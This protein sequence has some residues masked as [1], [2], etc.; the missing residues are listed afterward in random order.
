MRSKM[1]VRAAS[2]AVGAGLVLGTLVM[3]P[4]ATAATSGKQ[5]P[6]ET[7]ELCDLFQYRAWSTGKYKYVGD[8]YAYRPQNAFQGWFFNTTTY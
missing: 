7:R 8:C 3:G 5:G 1:W 6:F 2:T 4:A